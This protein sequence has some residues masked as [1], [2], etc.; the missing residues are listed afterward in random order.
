MRGVLCRSLFVLA[1][2]ALPASAWSAPVAREI[3]YA[4]KTRLAFPARY[5]FRFSL[6][7][8]ASGGAA[9]LWQEEKSVGLRA[10]STIR[11]HLGD[12]NP[13]VA[14]HF[15]QQLWVQVERRTSRG[16]VILG[17]RD[18]LRAAPY[19][20]GA[21]SGGVVSVSAAAGVAAFSGNATNEVNIGGYVG[22]HGMTAT[23]EYIIV[24]ISLPDGVTITGFSYTCYDNSVGLDS[25]ASLYNGLS[26]GGDNS[27]ELASVSTS[28]A[29]TTVQ[30]VSTTTI[31]NPVVNN[32][33]HTYLAYMSVHGSALSDL[34]AIKVVVTYE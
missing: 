26:L 3:P 18:M 25:T 13:L 12:A 10:D 33:L 30:T 23:P 27:A 7:D 31:T 34:T 28:G 21:R 15:T 22:R 2:I 1:S 19:A 29:S 16:Y 5:A 4:K 14:A 8:S 11:T 17:P 6:W 20:L 32:S 9:P 24:P